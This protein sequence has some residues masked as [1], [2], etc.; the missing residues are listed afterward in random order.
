MAIKIVLRDRFYIPTEAVDMKAL[1]IVMEVP[2]SSKEACRPQCPLASA[3]NRW[4]ATCPSKDLRI[5]MWQRVH[6][7]G[8]RDLIAIPSGD[9]E[10]LKQVV[11]GDVKIIDRRADVRMSDRLVW[12]GKLYN[13]EI[14]S[15][16][17][18]RPNQREMLK[19]WRK[20]VSVETGGII[21]SAPRTGKTVMG[22]AATM[23]TRRRSF[24]TASKIDFLR[25]FGKRFGEMTNLKE[26]YANGH[27]PV[28]LIDPKKW[29]DGPT[30]GVH[31]IPKW[32]KDVHKADV[33]LAC[34][35]QLLDTTGGRERMKEY[36][37]GKF[38]LVGI[39]E[40]HQAAAACLSRIANRINAR[41]KLGL[42]ATILRKD[43]LE[44]VALAVL[45]RVAAI[46]RVSSTLPVIKL[47][48]TGIGVKREYKNWS[49]ME[50]FLV[51]MEERNHI[52]VRNVFRDLRKNPK[53]NVLI[54]TTR[55]AHIHLL[56]KMINEQAE[57]NRKNKDEEWPMDLAVAYF[58]K[59]D[60]NSVLNL[61]SQGK[62]RVVVGMTSMIKYGLD[63][64]RWTHS[65]IGIIPT[66]NAPNFY[67]LLNR[68]CT[69]YS[70]DLEK[71]I[72]EKPTPVVRIFIDEMSASVYCFAKL[73]KDKN[74]GIE[75]FVNGK[76]YYNIKLARVGPETLDR[77]ETIAKYPKSYSASDA[78]VKQNL[79]RTKRG[80]VRRGSAWKVERSVTK[81]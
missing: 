44:N 74:F 10:L 63:V 73:F 4:C 36:I 57:Y 49:R 37:D 15:K 30:Y 56:C 61:V 53:H 34:Y 14:D 45:G 79:G 76:N 18:R 35:Q 66:S 5:K 27:R 16:G 71:K 38:G 24:F 28:V 6:T 75:G 60:T 21:I 1:K 13:G 46:G 55:V 70:A 58:G 80:H 20:Q 42:T 12:T 41:R 9:S 62:A 52:I 43:N 33:V 26:L 69:P 64:E 3:R 17:K 72:G 32:N 78:G 54:A 29:K 2:K 22:V 19:K 23:S 31:V 47:V 51:N 48:E 8:G 59:S 7:S 50:T 25:Q 77:M 65:Y 39:D 68:V 67:Q 40:A 11:R 81:L